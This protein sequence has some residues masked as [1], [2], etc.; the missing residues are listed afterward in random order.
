MK[1]ER[2]EQQTYYDIL[3]VPNTAAP[4]EIHAAYQRAKQ[5]YSTESPA[6]YTMFTQEEAKALIVLIEEAYLTLSNQ[7]RRKLYDQKLVNRS[8]QDLPDFKVAEVI[9][10]QRPVA[11][12]TPS[13]MGKTKF[14]LYPLRPEMEKEITECTEFDGPFIKKVRSYKKITLEQMCDET[15]INKPY[16]VALEN[17]DFKQLPAPV[18]VRGFVIQLARL[19]GVNEKKMTDSYIQMMKKALNIS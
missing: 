3:E 12:G 7:A 11:A 5:T 19:M 6:L 4:Q 17:N 1:S 16:L 18:F 8:Q 15:R 2:F 14:G 13:G 10:P 9:A